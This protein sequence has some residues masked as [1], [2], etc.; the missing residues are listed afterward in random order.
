MW[1][2]IRKKF[3]EEISLIKTLRNKY[4]AHNEAITESLT[5]NPEIVR[6]NSY[7]SKYKANSINSQYIEIGDSYKQYHENK[8]RES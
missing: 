8:R 1:E 6:I 3:K 5:F 7:W 4:I 2:I